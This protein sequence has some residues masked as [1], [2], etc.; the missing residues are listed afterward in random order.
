MSMWFDRVF[1]RQAGDQGMK[2]LCLLILSTFIS[3]R[4]ILGKKTGDHLKR[5]KI[6]LRFVICL[7]WFITF[8]CVF[9]SVCMSVP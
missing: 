4:F 6:Q 8:L 2:D 3:F 5:Q 7:I 9:L 1:V